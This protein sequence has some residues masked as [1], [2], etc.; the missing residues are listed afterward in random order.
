MRTRMSAL[1][2]SSHTNSFCTAS[3]RCER[4]NAFIS[5]S[6]ADTLF[7]GKMN[8]F[9]CMFHSR[10]RIGARTLLS[11]SHA[12]TPT[13]ADKNVR[14]PAHRCGQE[15]PRSTKNRDRCA[16]FSFSNRT[17]SPILSTA[18]QAGFA[19][20]SLAT[21]AP[22][23]CSALLLSSLTCGQSRAEPHVVAPAARVV[24]VAARRPAAAR[25]VG[26][27]AAPKHTA[28]A[29]SGTT[30]VSLRTTRV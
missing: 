14:A 10:T 17:H 26:P 6:A 11:A 13:V 30:W 27:T 16:G 12:G 9:S 3:T 28:R 22:L 1:R 4:K 29:R 8:C 24:A 7:N 25:G 19:R 21:P 20:P 15:C 5:A 2:L 23:L 18:P